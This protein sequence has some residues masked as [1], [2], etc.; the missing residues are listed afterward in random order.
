MTQKFR[1]DLPPL[2]LLLF[3]PQCLAVVTRQ[4]PFPIF[5]LSNRALESGSLHVFPTSTLTTSCSQRGCSAPSTERQ[6]S[7][8]L[9]GFPSS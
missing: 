5:L 8:P 3:P 4:S 7:S 1:L 9:V 6:N 2:P